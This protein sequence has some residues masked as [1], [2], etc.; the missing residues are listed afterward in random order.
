M[1][2]PHVFGGTYFGQQHAGLGHQVAARLNLQLERAA[3]A[4]RDLLAGRVPQAE[5]VRGVYGGLA[6][7]IGD[8]Q[9]AAG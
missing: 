8:R 3:L 2:A 1:V 6:G 5:V 7:P 9:A 4:L